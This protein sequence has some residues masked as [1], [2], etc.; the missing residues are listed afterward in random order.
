MP[1]FGVLDRAVFDSNGWLHDLA[2][3]H[4]MS[5]NWSTC[6]P[7]T[8]RVLPNKPKRN[9]QSPAETPEE[10]TKGTE[11]TEEK[12]TF[13]NLHH[14]HTPLQSRLVLRTPRLLLLLLLHLLL[15]LMAGCGSGAGVS[16]AGGAGGEGKPKGGGDATPFPTLVPPIAT[17]TVDIAHARAVFQS[18][19]ELAYEEVLALR[20]DFV[21]DPS[22]IVKTKDIDQIHKAE[23]EYS[24]RERDFE[25]RL[26]K[27]KLE[28]TI[29]WVG[30]VQHEYDSNNNA[31]PD[32]NRV[33]MN[34]SNPFDGP[35]K[36]EIQPSDMLAVHLTDKEV[37]PLKGGQR[38]T[39][40]GDLLAVDG[41]IAVQNVK[42][43][44]LADDPPVRAPTV[45][46]MKDL[47]VTLTRAACNGTCPIYTVT[48]NAEGKVTFVGQEFTDTKGTATDAID[49]TKLTELA[50]EIR[51]ADFFSLNASYFAFIA[52]VPTYTLTV[53]MGGQNKQVTSNALR[54]RR[55]V[56]LMDR[57]DQIAN[58]AQWIGNG[59]R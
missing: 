41:Q 18:G 56:I 26:A 6:R 42:Y 17:P 3:E 30:G 51:K 59:G 5:I 15:C 19:G 54:P 27:C 47:T 58:T 11:G 39:L 12:D 16:R 37:S 40:S 55:L 32:Q 28:E 36:D 21:G 44:L 8:W 4:R 34:L 23:D 57:V 49:S 45:E 31:I 43:A 46:E 1:T 2:D 22:D 7:S 9:R 38:I 29:G 14:T 53:Q 50:T 10:G 35:G 48:I 25:S 13:M 20:L 52:D 33:P 24:A